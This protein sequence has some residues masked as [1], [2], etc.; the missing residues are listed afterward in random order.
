[1][2]QLLNYFVHSRNID[3]ENQFRIVIEDC[4]YDSH[5]ATDIVDLSEGLGAEYLMVKGC[6]RADKL[7][8]IARFCQIKSEQFQQQC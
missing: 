6:Q 8:K 4:T 5:I 1:M 3:E 7:Q 2:S